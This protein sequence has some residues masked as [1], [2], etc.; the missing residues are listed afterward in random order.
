MPHSTPIYT[1]ATTNTL[2]HSSGIP[3]PTVD[4]SIL[5]NFIAQQIGNL[6]E[7]LN[8]SMSTMFGEFCQL[9]DDRLNQFGG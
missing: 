6:T 7:T 1:Q 5:Q 4:T 8:S 2:I 3:A 9:V